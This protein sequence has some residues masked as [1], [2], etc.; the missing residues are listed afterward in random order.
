MT[1]QGELEIDINLTG[2]PSSGGGSFPNTM[3]SA[4][5]PAVT[6]RG[7]IAQGGTLGLITINT[8]G[9]VSL[10]IGAGGSSTAD[11]AGTF[12]LD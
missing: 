12:A 7:V 1:P 8:T 2:T 10:S 5:R 6:K 9:V 3:P 11:F 4:Y